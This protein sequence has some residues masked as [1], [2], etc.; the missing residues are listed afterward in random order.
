MNVKR[1]LREE[2][3]QKY[4]IICPFPHWNRPFSNRALSSAKHKLKGKLMQKKF[5][6][7]DEN[8]SS[9]REMTKAA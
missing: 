6:R 2:E 3:V 8:T 4:R 9:R 1:D 5:E 7:K